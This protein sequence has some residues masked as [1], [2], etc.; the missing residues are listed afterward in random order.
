MFYGPSIEVD[1][2]YGL[3]EFLTARGWAPGEFSDPDEN[4]YPVDPETS[5]EY[6]PSFHGIAFHWFNDLS[7]SPLQCRFSFSG[8]EASGVEVEE[9]GNWKGCAEHAIIEHH[10]PDEPGFTELAALLDQLEPRARDL[11]PR[12]LIECRF[13]GDCGAHWD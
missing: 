8:D 9:A 6:H 5:W 12:A 4:G 11:D 13:F 2:L 1:R 10:V 7:P 3:H